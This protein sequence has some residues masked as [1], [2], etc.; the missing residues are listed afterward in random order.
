MKLKVL[1][2]N[3]H[4]GFSTTGLSFTLHAIREAL[5]ITNCDILL[6]QEVVGQNLTHQKNLDNWPTQAQFEFLADSHWQHYS[7]GKNAIFPER[8]HGNA[9]LSKFPIVFE[10]NVN[11]SLNRLEQRGLLHCEI[12]IPEIQKKLHVFNTHIDLFE[13]SRKK[14]SELIIRRA[15]SHL[16]PDVPFIFGGDFNDWT[17]NLNPIFTSQLGV[18]E[19]HTEIHKEPAK[20]FPSF[21]PTLTLDRLYFRNAGIETCTTLKG[22]PWT[23]L[24]DHLPLYA[25]FDIS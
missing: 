3:I 18:F 1:S 5:R 23:D 10:E 12:L 7:Y 11:I 24:S 13:S 25:E 19:S 20:S 6:L 14:Q 9:V 22:K 15:Q 8:H 21:F 2:Y 17:Q 4:K 16:P